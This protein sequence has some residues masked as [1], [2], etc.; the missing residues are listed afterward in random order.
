M[1]S[2]SPVL[3]LATSFRAHIVCISLHHCPSISLLNECHESSA[4]RLEATVTQMFTGS[5][6]FQPMKTHIMFSDV[7]LK[8]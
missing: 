6:T 7:M 3:P 1:I 8:M 5:N 4:W 2:L